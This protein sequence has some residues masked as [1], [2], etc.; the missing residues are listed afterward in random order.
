MKTVLKWL[1]LT[2]AALMAVALAVVLS[3]YALFKRLLTYPMGSAATAVGW[4]TPLELV[5]EGEV[6]SFPEGSPQNAGISLETVR[7]AIDYGTSTNSVALLVMH[8]GKLV[9]EHYWPGYGV[10]TRTDPASMH[11]SVLSLLFGIALDEGHID[12]LDDPINKYL[13][14]WSGQPEGEIPLRA[15]LTMA[16]GLEHAPLNFNPFSTSMQ[17]L[18]GTDISG[19]ALSYDLALPP[20]TEFGYNNVNSQLLGMVIEA[21]TGVRYA[22]FL[23]DRLWSRIGAPRAFVWLDDDDG[24]AHTFCCL[25]TTARGWLAVGNLLLNE[26]RYGGEQIVPANYLDE[27][28]A[29]SRNNP[30]YGFQIWLG[31]PH[32][33]Q[34]RYSKSTELTVT[35]SQPY[36]ADDL[37]YFDGFGGQRVYVIPS[38]ELVI[39]RT[40]E[41][42]MD[43]DDAIIPNLFL[44]D[45][46]GSAAS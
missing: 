46:L 30:N 28:L 4:Y 39:I 18:I 24:M 3:N 36:L 38:A 11:K 1:G 32:T 33:Q 13:Q 19:T 21:A 44:R 9:V 41:Q 31:S 17:M 35:H 45:V 37:Y 5:R 27:A 42:R 2:L 15:L 29:P 22:Q 12:S 43:W 8:D 25:Q 26:G 10:D 14:E 6:A 7:A 20:F 23:S 34:R 16:S 40:G